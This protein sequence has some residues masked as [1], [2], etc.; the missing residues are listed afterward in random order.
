[1]HIND[2]TLPLVADVERIFSEHAGDELS[3]RAWLEECEID[4]G[5]II[6]RVGKIAV[7]SYA[8][9]WNPE[10]GCYDFRAYDVDHV[11]PKRQPALAVPIMESGEFVDLLL[12]ADDMSFETVCCRARWLGRDNLKG[13]VR[14]HRH[15][16]DWLEAGCTGCCHVALICRQALKELSR[17]ESITCNDIDTA[18]NAW[19]W[20]FDS[21]DAELSRFEI[22][23]TAESIR[24]YFGEQ[25]KCQA[26]L[27]AFR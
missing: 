5:P 18:L 1:M 6:E 16:L 12:I 17:A 27:E 15:P 3:A 23:D 10:T 14:L 13:A 11:G 26:P 20:G 4:P 24:A 21:D 22:D 8:L 7:M 25:A 19:G 2:D 9:V